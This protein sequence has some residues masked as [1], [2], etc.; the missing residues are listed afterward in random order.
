[1]AVFEIN[2][3]IETADATILV[4]VPAEGSL[5]VGRHRFQL[6]VVD[7]SD[8][9]SQPDMVTVIVR[10]TAAPTA[11]LTAPESVSLNAPFTL[12]GQ[13]SS[14]VGGGRIVRYVW[15]YLGPAPIVI[16]A[17]RN[18]SETPPIRPSG[19]GVAEPS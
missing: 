1:M 6:V 5:R 12:S 18:N 11:V 14:D 19:P 17:D 9:R 3:P 10:D 2:V 4:E 7:D 16:D 15:T 8:N 13:D